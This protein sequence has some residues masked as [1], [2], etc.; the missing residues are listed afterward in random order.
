MTTATDPWQISLALEQ[1]LLQISPANGYATSAGANVTL[2]IGTI[3]A[4]PALFLVEQEESILER[5]RNDGNTT[6]RLPFIIEGHIECNPDRANE[7]AHTLRRDIQ[8]ALFGP[9]MN[10]ESPQAELEYAGYAILPREPGSKTIIVHINFQ[11][12]H[13]IN[14]RTP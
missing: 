9:G 13:Q 3:S 6:V 14:I 12:T 4:T 2:G 11:S 8:K 7:A 1:R 10:L 5:V